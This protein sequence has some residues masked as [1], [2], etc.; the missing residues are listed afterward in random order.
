MRKY[1]KQYAQDTLMDREADPNTILEV[2]NVNHI[3]PTG[4]HAIKSISLDVP[5]G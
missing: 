1:K 5:K 2:N 4:T 3:Y